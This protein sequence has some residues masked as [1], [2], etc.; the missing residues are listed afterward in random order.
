MIRRIFLLLLSVIVISSTVFSRNELKVEVIPLSIPIM[1][2]HLKM[3]HSGPVGKEMIVN[4]KYLTVGGRPV[5]PV[6]GELHFSRVAREQWR[7]RLLKMKANGI[8]IVATYLFWIHHEEA[9]GVFE[10]DGSKDFREFIKLCQELGLYIYPRV[11]PWCHGE[12]RNGGTPD[13]ILK[14]ELIGN[15]TNDPVYQSYVKRYFKEIARQ[16][17][18]LL[19][20]DGGPIIGI[21]LENEYWRG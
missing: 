4:N 7:D 6:M 3:G 20:K 11:G 18:G 9:E 1:E 8:T 14:K 12:V 13:W 2:G 19:Y 21:Q 10:W 17:E 5:I 15:R 16:M